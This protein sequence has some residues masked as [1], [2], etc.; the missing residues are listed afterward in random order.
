MS[1]FENMETKDNS[2]A[3][4]RQFDIPILLTFF[5]REETLVRVFE[6]IREVKPKTL[7]L[8]SDGPRKDHPNDLKKI[9]MCRKIVDNIDWDCEVHRYYAEENLGI[10]V[11]ANLAKK[12]A[13]KLVDRLIFLEDDVLPSKDFFLFCR[14]MLIR[15]ESE[16]KVS[17]ISGSNPYDLNKNDPSGYFFVKQATSGATAYWK[18]T[19]EEL[20]TLK[21]S[22][23]ERK[24]LDKSQINRLPKSLRR[25]IIKRIVKQTSEK[26][27][28]FIS[29]ELIRSIYFYLYDKLGVLPNK[30]LV[31]SISLS[32]DSAHSYDDLRKLP[33]AL[34]KLQ[35]YPIS[36]MVFPLNH[37]DQIKEDIKSRNLIYRKLA[38]GHPYIQFYRWIVTSFLI[39]RYGSLSELIQKM[40]M[41]IRFNLTNSINKN[42]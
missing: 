2:Q 22:I 6:A 30:N 19:Y 41:W 18:R 37:H 28:E 35:G 5:V 11:N 3:T 27:K 21:T 10:M 8:A 36:S 25:N 20:E 12:K 24:S 33:K 16:H 38:K 15:Y 32:K 39:L 4:F 1:Q 9:E 31:S 34:R 13:F 7:F 42:G 26:N 14:E 23:L 40:K 17:I 29:G